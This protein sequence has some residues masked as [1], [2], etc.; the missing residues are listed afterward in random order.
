[1]N[2][3]G[4][5]QINVYC[6]F[7]CTTRGFYTSH[8]Q[9]SFEILLPIGCGS[10]ESVLLYQINNFQTSCASYIVCQSLIQRL[11]HELGLLHENLWHVRHETEMVK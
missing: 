8:T 11:I 5:R 4:I 1:M 10:H 6:K 3:V 7:S 2:H 9:L